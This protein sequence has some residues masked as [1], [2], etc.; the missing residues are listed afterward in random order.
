MTTKKKTTIALIAILSISVFSLTA[1]AQVRDL[2][3]DSLL[4][5]LPPN[6]AISWNDPATGNILG[7]DLYGKWN[8]FFGLGL[9]TVV[10][11]KV[12]AR[13]VGGGNEQVTI[14]LHVR[15]AF[16]LGL[17]GDFQPALGYRPTDVIDGVG[18]AATG[19]ATAK[20]VMRPAPAGQFNFSLAQDKVERYF[21]TI[22]C[23]GLLRAG[24]GYPEGTPGFG[25]TTQVAFIGTGCPIVIDGFCVPEER[26]QF[27]PTGN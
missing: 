18:P 24:S 9:P 17:N 4:D 11:G 26:I 16:C 23:S 12:T 1:P 13:D 21:T 20:F 27:R 2:G 19:D 3:I 5:Q 22:N 15:N 7:I 25:H 14:I 8:S 10:S 6:A